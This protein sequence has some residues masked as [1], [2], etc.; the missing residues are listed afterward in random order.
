MQGV[1]VAASMGPG[2]FGT[3][4]TG[5]PATGPCP[6]SCFNGA[7]FFWNREV[8]AAAGAAAFG[9]VA[10]M[11]PGSFGTGKKSFLSDPF[12]RY[13]ELQWGPVLLEPGSVASHRCLAGA[14]PQCASM[15][16]G[17]F[18]TGK[19]AVNFAHGPALVLGFNGA[20]FFWNRED[21]QSHRSDSTVL[22]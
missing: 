16:P 1:R 22:R 8:G 2:S 20:R 12:D 10:S 3:G 9:F 5:R 15:G 4:K 11:G 6:L 21:D 14:S 13:R 18:G 7:R 17:S 19:C